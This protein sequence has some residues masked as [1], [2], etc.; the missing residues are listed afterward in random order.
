R[1]GRS[2]RFICFILFFLACKDDSDEP[3]NPVSTDSCVVKDFV[4]ATF[5]IAFEYD[6]QGRISKQK[7]MTL[8][9]SVID[10]QAFDYSTSGKVFITKTSNLYK[11][12]IT[13]NAKGDAQ[14]KKETYYLT[15]NPLEIDIVQET[16]YTYNAQGYLI[17]EKLTTIDG[18]N[19]Y[20]LNY[21]STWLDG[22]LLTQKNVPEVGSQTIFNYTYYAD[23]PNGLGKLERKYGFNGLKSKNLAKTREESKSGSAAKITTYT[24]TKDSKGNLAT[25][26]LSVAGSPDDVST[27]NWSCK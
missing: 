4:T 19:T 27:V 17:N 5:K 12:E 7:F 25:M 2:R 6:N 16:E 22:N 11:C 14:T 15:L 13:L 3:V 8:K 26:T 24:Y 1:G 9:D 10:F 21:Q 18:S 23:M 20:T